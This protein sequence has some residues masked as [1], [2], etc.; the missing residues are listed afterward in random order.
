MDFRIGQRIAIGAY[1]FSL[2]DPREARRAHAEAYAF[3][4]DRDHNVG[5]EVMEALEAYTVK[6]VP[7]TRRTDYVQPLAD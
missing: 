1:L 6:A 4:N 3:L 5:G 7:W 2:T